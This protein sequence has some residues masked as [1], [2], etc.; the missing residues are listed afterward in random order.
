M[1]EYCT[2]EYKGKKFTAIATVTPTLCLTEGP[3][4]PSSI[5]SINNDDFIALQKETLRLSEL[6]ESKIN[7]RPN[8]DP[9]QDT[10]V[11]SI[12]LQEALAESEA[13]YQEQ[14]QRLID[15]ENEYQT[16]KNLILKEL[17]VVKF[18]SIE[19]QL[20]S[21]EQYDK[22]LKEKLVISITIWLTE[23]N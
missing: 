8:N 16:S 17:E 22:L 3:L 4:T 14:S 15:L 13:R 21:T 23:S 10:K 6:I 12:R 11:A 2:P 9:I 1:A 18:K 20:K 7:L 5:N 19:E